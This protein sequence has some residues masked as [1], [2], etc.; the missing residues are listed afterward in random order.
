MSNRKRL[1]IIIVNWNVRELLKECLDSV[2]RETAMPKE[3]FEVFV[4]DNDSSDGSVDM[5]KA[6]FPDVHLVAN[7]ENVGF[8][9][10]NNQVLD[11]CRGEYVLL[12][13]PD[14]M[15]INNAIDKL[16]DHADQ[17]KNVA[18]WGARL[19]NV[20]HSLQR[21]TGGSFPNI[22]NITGHYLF[23]S[24]LLSY[25]G[26]TQSLYLE[27]DVDVDVDVDWVSG[28]CM[29][30]RSEA[31]DNKLFDDRFFMY[32]EDMEL[33]H[34][35][36]SG[37]W[38]IVYTPAASVVHVQGASM[39]SQEGDILLSSLKGLRSFYTLLHGKQKVW[40]VD[41]I[42]ILGFGVRWGLYSILGF[43]TR[44]KH[45]AEKAKSSLSYI[46][47]TQ[48]IIQQ[49]RKLNDCLQQKQ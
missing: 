8:G 15:A 4:V 5:V 44:K 49:E 41:F 40:L 14:A 36:K 6:H 28:A 2:Y 35:L 19:L 32:G 33:C 24:R 31:L 17:Q 13:N 42:T 3:Q 48:K 10:A 46:H 22:M 9:K 7:T 30:L 29:L 21:W 37:G 43:F 18:V 39:K 27:T 12:F 11:Q 45:Y 23:I 1:S 25:F 26:S 38:R 47:I 20:D 16:L 34:R